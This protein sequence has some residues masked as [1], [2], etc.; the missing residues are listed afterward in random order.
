M[1]DY[2]N[3]IK[4]QQES[5]RKISIENKN[6]YQAV[7]IDKTDTRN[8]HEN[9]TLKSNDFTTFDNQVPNSIHHDNKFRPMSGDLSKIVKFEDQNDSQSRMKGKMPKRSASHQYTQKFMK[10]K[11]QIKRK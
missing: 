8:I 9:Q 3:K 7:E 2:Q 10:T 11:S 4:N 6:F 1:E 5:A